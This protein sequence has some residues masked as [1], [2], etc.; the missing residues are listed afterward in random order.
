M[1]RSPGWANGSDVRREGQRLSQGSPVRAS[2]ARR[3]GV[4][5]LELI[6]VLALLG[7]V[8]AIAAPSFLLPSTRPEDAASAALVAARRQAVIRGEPVTVSINGTRV[9]VTPLGTCIPEATG[10]ESRATW[11]AVACSAAPT[12]AEATAR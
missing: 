5:L 12:S 1:S 4:T 3:R 2:H 10:R 9:H 7:L 11:D 8:L 6:V